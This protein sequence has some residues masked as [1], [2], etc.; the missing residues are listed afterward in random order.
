MRMKKRS[1]LFTASAALLYLTLSSYSG[2]PALNGEGNKT[3]SPG[4]SG[5]CA[6]CHT[7]GSSLPATTGSI[8]LR[9]KI[10][11]A[12]STPVTYY[13]AGETYIVTLKGT[14]SASSLTHFGFQ[15]TALKDADNS[16]VG[17][18][19]NLGTNVHGVPATSPNL[20]EQSAAIGKNGSGDYEVS[21]EWTAP[22]SGEGAV[23]LYAIINAV[24]N[25]GSTMDDKP[26]S[27]ISLALKDVTG[28]SEISNTISFKAYPNPVQNTLNLEVDNADPGTYF[29]N[30]YSS[31]GALVYQTQNVV[32][33]LTSTK[34]IDLS[35]VTPGMYYVKVSKD[36][37]STTIPVLK[38]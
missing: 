33:T 15:F 11:G 10:W 17:T 23:T 22:A 27:T 18:Y 36:G 26:S 19:G 4:S 28:V 3:G 25:T 16:A 21:F 2:G 14:N 20:V 35:G 6:T 7:G 5:T 8:E 1:L 34:S 31:T 30:V 24:N 12:S 37:N 13:E 32:N 29:I 38:R 9:K